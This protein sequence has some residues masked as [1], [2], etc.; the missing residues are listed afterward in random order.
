MTKKD[1]IKPLEETKPNLSEEKVDNVIRQNKHVIRLLES[2]AKS[3]SILDQDRN[4][5]EN[6]QVTAKS[7]E[8]LLQHHR[9]HQVSSNKDLKSDVS[10]VAEKVEE[11]KE[12]VQEAIKETMHDIV[13]DPKKPRKNSVLD[14]FLK[15]IKIQ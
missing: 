7:I 9:E 4:I 11:V 13:G 8:T 12:E 5:L 2:I 15:L 10:D 1:T 14:R 6:I 3:I